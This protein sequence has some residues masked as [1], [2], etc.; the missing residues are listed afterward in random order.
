MR[1]NNCG[2]YDIG[3]NDIYCPHCGARLYRSA[4]NRRGPVSEEAYAGNGQRYMPY[5][6]YGN[7]QNEGN[8]GS[9]GNGG[10]DGNNSSKSAIIIT[11]AIILALAIV[12]GALYM[13]LAHQDEEE[14]WAQCEQTN[15]IAD[16]KKYI[17]EYPDGQHYDEAK[18]KYTLLINEKSMWEQVQASN[19]EYQIRQFI[20]NHRQ[21]KYLAKAKELLDDVMWNNVIEKNTKQDVERYMR[22]YPNGKHIADARRKIEEYRLSELTID[23]QEQVRNLVQQFLSGLEQWSVVQMLTTCNS[24]MTNFMGTEPATHDDV[25]EYYDAFEESD[26]DSIAFSA[27]NLNVKKSFSEEHQPQFSVSFTVTRRFWRDGNDVPTTS[28]MQGSALIDS[29]FRFEEFTMDKVVD[30]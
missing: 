2:N 22:E 7:N 8:Y 13:G 24:Y 19:D 14:L 17:E 15:E 25:R 11:V 29:F 4:N 10:R 6:S 20:N 9:Q 1:C 26:I 23:E 12:G 3:A 21:S 30:N 5:R 28:L 18:K 16:Y 27:L